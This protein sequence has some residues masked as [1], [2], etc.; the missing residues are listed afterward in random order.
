MQD[1]AP[2]IHA[3][4]TTTPP[5][6]EEVL[7]SI[8]AEELRDLNEAVASLKGERQLEE[9]IQELK[10]EREE[11]REVRP[12]IPQYFVCDTPHVGCGRVGRR[13]PSGP[14]GSDGVQSI[15]AAG[16]E[17]RRSDSSGGQYTVAAG[18]GVCVRRQPTGQCPV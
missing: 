9:E 10:E 17:S 1:L 7:G 14:R 11:Y 8:S 13:E 5:P 18:E 3:A 15:S 12:A 6:T 2:V 16:K 4:V